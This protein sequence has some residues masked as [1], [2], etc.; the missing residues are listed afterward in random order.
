MCQHPDATWR[1]RILYRLPVAAIEYPFEV[2]MSAMCAIVGAPL[3]A[4]VVRS[5]SMTDLLP[6]PIP[7][8]WGVMLLLGAL[9]ILL[10][11]WRRAYGT[12]VAAGL[13]LLAC[14][15]AA[16]G[17]AVGMVAGVERAAPSLALIAVV[18]LLCLARSYWLRTRHLLAARLQEWSG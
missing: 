14:S 12:L 6:D 4:G 8:I 16:Y 15:C 1:E 18:A 10:G 7:R 9:T 2:L 3:T 17:I 5:Q 13:R 11:L